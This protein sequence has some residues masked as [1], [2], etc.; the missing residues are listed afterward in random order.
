MG[1]FKN[2]NGNQPSKLIARVFRTRGETHK[3][4]DK[5]LHR[6][7]Y[8]IRISNHIDIDWLTFLG[9][10]A[11]SFCFFPTDVDDDATHWKPKI[12]QCAVH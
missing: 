8:P 5:I 12:E 1:S 11:I 6:G 7:T 4:I 3:P 9:L 10:T 2:L